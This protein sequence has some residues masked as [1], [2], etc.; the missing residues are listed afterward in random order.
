MRKFLAALVMVFGAARALAGDLYDAGGRTFG[1]K[2]VDAE[3][4]DESRGR[5]VPVRMYIPK[6]EEGA[7]EQ[8][9][10]LIVFSHG[11]GASREMYGYFGKHMAEIGYV[12]I[13]PTHHGSDT[14]ALRAWAK[15]NGVG[16]KNDEGEGWLQAGISDP[17]NLRN[18]PR[19]ISFVI[20]RAG[21]VPELAGK[22]DFERIGVAGHSFGAYT[23]CAVGGMT[24]D[25]PDA[26]GASFRD[27]RVKAILPMS[28]QGSGTM[29]ITQESWKGVVVPVFFLTGTNDYGNGG[30]AASWRREGFERVS[31]VD[32][33]LF[34]IDGATHM[35]FGGPRDSAAMGA[36]EEEKGGRLRA[37]IRDRIRERVREKTDEKGGG[38]DPDLEE[39][40]EMTLAYASAFFDAY[41]RGDEKAT[42]WLVEYVAE[43]PAGCQA[44]FKAGK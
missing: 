13:A 39:H 28:P 11:L 5:D 35:T 14:E 42:K 20:D 18:R 41:V 17:E 4:R 22:I 32:D 37:R 19:D 30:R 10:P 3:W 24:V 44:E 6:L 25:L 26:K 1:V 43:K 12:V 40:S 33:Y 8:R 15:E 38:R 7:G 29:G 34:T 27:A 23:S 31:G 36:S 9:L 21:K 2:V 16:K